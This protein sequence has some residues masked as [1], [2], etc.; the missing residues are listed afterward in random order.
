M[1]GADREIEAAVRR[2]WHRWIKVALEMTMAE[3][4]L[5]VTAALVD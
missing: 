5:A 1:E 3:G 2:Q 4:G